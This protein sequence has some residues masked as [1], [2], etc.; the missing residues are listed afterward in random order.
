MWIKK[1]AT[2]PLTAVAKVIDSLSEQTNDRYN[3]PSIRAVRELMLEN[4]ES[5]YPVGSIYM[6]TNDV[7]PGSLFGGTWSQIKDKFL[8]A[9]GNAHANGTEGGSETHTPSGTVGNHALQVNELPSHGHNYTKATGVGNHTLTVD[10]IPSHT[11]QYAPGTGTTQSLASGSQV[12]NQPPLIPLGETFPTGGG[13]GHNHPLTTETNVTANTGSGAGH[14]HGFTGT[15]QN[16]MPPYL[17][18]NVWVRVA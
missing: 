7:N 9:S 2:T 8:L 17:A 14:N 18:V 3:A 12:I 1:V 13:A 16:T 5:V 4:W 6:T 10:E 11:H 15:T